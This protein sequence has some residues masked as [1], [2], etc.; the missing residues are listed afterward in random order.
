LSYLHSC[1]SP[2]RH[3]VKTPE[4]PMY[5]DAILPDTPLTGGLAPRLGAQHLQVITIREF[6]GESVPGFLDA[7]NRLPFE[8]RWITRFVFEDKMPAIKIM[9]AYQQKWLSGRQSF[10]TVIR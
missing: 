6:P 5:L 7:M 8:Y 3:R 2:K 1:I 4:T 9:K 10:M